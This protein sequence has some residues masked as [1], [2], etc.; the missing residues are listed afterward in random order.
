[1]KINKVLFA[2]LFMV[3]SVVSAA[4]ETGSMAPDFTL[5]DSKGVTHNLSDFKGKYVV[6]EWTRHNCPFVRKF[7]DGGDMQG[8]QAEMTK[9]DVIW[10]QMASSS[11]GK[12]GYL[13]AKEAEALREEQKIQSS[14]FLLD[15]TGAVGRAYAARTTPH[16]F[17][18]SPEGRVIYQGAIDSIKS[19]QSRDIAEATN[20]IKAAYQS[21]VAGQPIE[22]STT[23]PYGCGVKY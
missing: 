18:I 15:T 14:A 8:L 16:M 22:K 4:L 19:T 7:Y 17:L 1:M 3:A 20:Y 13:T 10:L 23:T 12:A 6:L 21:A 11:E 5:T 2:G 9:N